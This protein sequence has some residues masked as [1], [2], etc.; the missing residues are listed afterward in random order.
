MIVNFLSTVYAVYD[1]PE[2]NIHHSPKDERR[3]RLIWQLLP[4]N[5]FGDLLRVTD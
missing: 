3:S 2:L 5:E 1:P 4:D